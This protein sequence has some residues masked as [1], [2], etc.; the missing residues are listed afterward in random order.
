MARLRNQAELEQVLRGFDGEEVFRMLAGLSGRHTEKQMFRTMQFDANFAFHNP[1]VVELA[2][3][4]PAWP[5]EAILPFG[6]AVHPGFATI[7]AAWQAQPHL[8]AFIAGE[9]YHGGRNFTL[10]TNHGALF[11]IALVLGAL[12]IAIAKYLVPDAFSRRSTVIVSGGVRTLEVVLDI[13]GQDVALPA[14][15]ILQ[16]FARVL[17]SFPTTL[18]VKNVSFDR[19]LVVATNELVRL[20]H[21]ELL[22][23]GGQLVAMA[24]SA[25]EDRLLSDR[26]HMQP[27]KDGTMDLMIG[28]WALPVAVTLDGTEPS[29]CTILEPIL[30][31]S[32]ESQDQAKESCHK[33]MELIA[34]Q[35][36][37]QSLVEH[38]YHRNPSLYQRALG[39]YG[40]RQHYRQ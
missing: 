39:I 17:T 3:L 36:Y 34:Y 12:R 26:K 33:M 8:L 30:L 29:A 14:I 15:E 35:C 10:V 21:S 23:R 32:E 28:T 6:P 38:V 24:P 27:L 25:S 13:D 19:D 20:R 18:S 7:L 9:M 16:Y 5:N 22:A 1:E 4:Q 40:R 11:D 2:P 31:S 37:R